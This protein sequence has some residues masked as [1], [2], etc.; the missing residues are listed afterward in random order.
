MQQK[1]QLAQQLV[2]RQK[3]AAL[4]RTQRD[5]LNAMCR[6]GYASNRQVEEQQS[7]LLKSQARQQEYQR[8]LLDI[9]QKI[10]QVRQ[11]LMEKPL[12]EQRRRNEIERQLGENESRRAFEIRAPRAGTVGT[13]MVKTGQVVMAGQSAISVLPQDARLV[14]RIMV[15][16]RAIG[17]I[18]PGQKVVLR[19]QA[20]PWQK[21]GQQY[22]RVID[23][24]RTVLSPQEVATLTGNNNV[25]APQYRVLVQ[26]DR[27]A[28]SVYTR[29][30]PLRP[31][32]ALDADFLVDRRH[33][34]EW[35]L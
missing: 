11:Q 33:I 4:A 30:E 32:M 22:G 31:G 17:F 8:Q 21:F 24:S 7:N 6:E 26:L 12:Y 3:Q 23:V 10:M 29:H 18:E 34:Y 28:I 27:Q 35:V 25:K 1:A 16:T 15:D 5:K 9:E 14:A 20:F 2:H 13:I 19:Y